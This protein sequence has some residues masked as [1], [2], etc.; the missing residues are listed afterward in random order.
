MAETNGQTYLSTAAAARA[1]GVGVSTIKR[2]VDEEVLPAHR[3][4]GGHRKLLRAEILSL[5]RQGKLPSV[6]IAPLLPD[7][8]PGRKLDPVALRTSLTQATLSGD[9][10]R[11]R[12]LFRRART[13]ALP[14]DTLADQVI[15]PVMQRVGLEWEC[16]RIDVWQEHRGTQ[17]IAAMLHDLL[18]QLA[19]P[20]SHNRPLAVGAA[21]AGD[22]YFLG[23]L[24]AQ[25]ALVESGWRVV[26]LGPNTPLAS[27]AAAVERLRPRL[28]WISASHLVDPPQ[29]VRDY[30]LLQRE[31]N[32]QGVAIALG[33]QAMAA[34]L[35]EQLVYTMFGDGITQLVQFAS[36]LHPARPRP[37]RGRPRKTP[38]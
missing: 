3:T 13:A 2:W 38:G 20:A 14:L 19:P 29:F 35:R 37:R 25:M 30:R 5:A 11:I 6:D 36:T 32:R 4:S 16:Q 31:A 10:P 33:G 21:P 27:L 34:P 24:L 23:L 22:P 9:E 7:A 15:A 26:N 1:L 28:V 12:E 18:G 17:L 8:S